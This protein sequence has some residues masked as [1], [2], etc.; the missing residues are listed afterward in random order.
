M[1]PQYTFNKQAMLTAQPYKT[2]WFRCIDIFLDIWLFLVM[3]FK[4]SKQASS[5]AKQAPAKPLKRP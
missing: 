5:S 2:L 3:N 4:F 1:Q